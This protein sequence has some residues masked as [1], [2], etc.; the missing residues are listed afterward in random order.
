ML[1]QLVQGFCDNSLP[2]KQMTFVSFTFG[3]CTASYVPLFLQNE[4]A[5]KKFNQ[6]HRTELWN[7]IRIVVDEICFSTRS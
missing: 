2:C 6:N 1:L 5:G 3:F 4:F 7:L